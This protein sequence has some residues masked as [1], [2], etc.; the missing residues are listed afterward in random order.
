MTSSR[1]S[2]LYFTPVASWRSHR[3][4]WMRLRQLFRGA[5]YGGT[6]IFRRGGRLA[7]R[8]KSCRYL[9]QSGVSC[10]A[11]VLEVNPHVNRVSFTPLLDR[12]FRWACSTPGPRG[13]CGSMT[14]SGRYRARIGI[15]V[16]WPVATPAARW[17]TVTAYMPGTGKLNSTSLVTPGPERISAMCAAVP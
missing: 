11:Q 1:S 10:A 2:S 6:R 7:K 3:S 4:A 12:T 8:A 14:S 17:V 5:L 13:S 9:T 16:T 15:M